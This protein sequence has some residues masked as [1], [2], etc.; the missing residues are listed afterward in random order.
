MTDN[1]AYPQEGFIM[2]NLGWLFPTGIILLL[3]L[4]LSIG[5][6]LEKKQMTEHYN[7]WCVKLNS[8]PTQSR[9]SYL[10][11]PRCFT[12]ENNIIK[13]YSIEEINGEYKLREEK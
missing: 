5:I 4:G 7:E 6:P 8:S 11:P 10:S 2:R 1:S 3:V 12:E 9:E 13:L